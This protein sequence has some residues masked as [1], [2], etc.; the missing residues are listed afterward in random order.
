MGTTSFPF[1]KP[2]DNLNAELAS[3]L[4]IERFDELVEQ[5]IRIAD[6]YNLAF[7]NL[8]VEGFEAPPKS[9]ERMK[10]TYW[11]YTVLLPSN[12]SVNKTIEELAKEKIESRRV[13]KPMHEQPAFS[14][15]SSLE[16]SASGF[17]N[18]IEI[19]KRGLSLPTSTKL[20]DSQV[21]RV[22]KKLIELV[23]DK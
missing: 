2:Y 1:V 3:D 13:F 8:G 17:I 20:T 15:N 9:T 19:S 16:M 21:A 23:A 5:K 11:L 7:L 4:L 18:S 12:V 6:N 14:S 22:A 10:N